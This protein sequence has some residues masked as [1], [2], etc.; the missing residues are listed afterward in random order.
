MKHIPYLSLLTGLSISFQRF[1]QSTSDLFDVMKSTWF[2]ARGTE[3]SNKT[4]LFCGSLIY[5][6]KNFEC[7]ESI[8]RP[9]IRG[10]S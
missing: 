10:I 1:V 8:Y 7:F 5:I 4:P 2:P 6:E 9:R 3:F